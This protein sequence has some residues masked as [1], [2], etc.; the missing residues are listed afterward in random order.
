[1]N[2]EDLY[3]VWRAASPRGN[4]PPW[5]LLNAKSRLAWLAVEKAARRATLTAFRIN[6]DKV[7]L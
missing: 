5:R 7:T 3:K 2:A 6:P 4:P 1:M